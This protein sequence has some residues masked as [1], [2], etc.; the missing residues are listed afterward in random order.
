MAK[1]FFHTSMPRSGSTVLQNLMGQ[2]P[3]FYVTPTSGLI[4]LIYASKKAFTDSVEFNANLEPE[5]MSKAFSAYCNAGIHAFANSITDKKYFLDKG[6]GW[7]IYYNW[8]KSFLPY[9]PKMICMVRDLRDIFCSMEKLFRKDINKEPLVNWAT[10][11]NT[12]VAKRVDY[13]STTPPLGLALERFQ[14][15]FETNSF[16]K[17]LF[18][19]YEDFCL[20]P[21]IEVK[22]IYNYLEIP[23][24]NHNFDNIL[25]I[26][27]EDDNIHG[28]FGDHIIRPRLEMKQSDAKSILGDRVCDWIYDRYNWYFKTFGYNK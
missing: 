2:N 9:E 27:K 19:K 17:F 18:I 11:A 26:T 12:T 4:E 24:Y 7:G 3:D 8:I 10:G 15:I 23:H 14:V 1:L 13:F 16:E 28:V 6:R 21:E 20:R 5:V 22:R 25:Q